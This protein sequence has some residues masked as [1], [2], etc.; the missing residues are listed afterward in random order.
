M[1]EDRIEQLAKRLE[2]SF[3]A[4]FSRRDLEEAITA[5][6]VL[7]KSLKTIEAVNSTRTGSAIDKA[8]RIARQALQ[9]C[10]HE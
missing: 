10:N 5:L 1:A 8:R 6:R 4:G 2:N 9:D 3:D 7:R